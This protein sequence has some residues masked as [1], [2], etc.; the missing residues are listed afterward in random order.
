MSLTNKV[1]PPTEHGVA[2]LIDL[3]NLTERERLSSDAVLAFSNIMDHWKI[4]DDD[5]CRLLGG[6]PKN[7]YCALQ[8]GGNPGYSTRT[9]FAASPISSASSRR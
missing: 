6:I 3:R 7:D 8:K 1:R 4:D 5:A 9:S 2:P